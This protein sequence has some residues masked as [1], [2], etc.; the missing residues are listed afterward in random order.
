M[1]IPTYLLLKAQELSG[2]LFQMFALG[3]LGWLAEFEKA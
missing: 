3:L 2:H 1:A